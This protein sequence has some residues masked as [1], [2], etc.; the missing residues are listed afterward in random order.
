MIRRGVVGP[1]VLMEHV[2]M[3]LKRKSGE[4]KSNDVI[5][6]N[7]PPL[8]VGHAREEPIP[9]HARRFQ[10][11][12]VGRAGRVTHSSVTIVLTGLEE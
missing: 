2:A 4:I 10:K 7:L 1:E 12:I 8:A 5:L 9:A 6:T 11:H 3:S